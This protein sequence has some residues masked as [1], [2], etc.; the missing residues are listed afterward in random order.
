MS[1][2]DKR[3]Q[4]NRALMAASVFPDGLEPRDLNA[5]VWRFMPV[6]FFEDLIK[7]RQ[8]YFARMDRFDDRHEGL[9][10]EDYIHALRL[11]RFD[12]NDI[13]ARDHHIGDIACGRRN[14][15]ASCWY[16]FGEETATMWTQFAPDGG[17]AV[18]STYARLKSVI[19]S[20]PYRPHIGL[21]RYGGLHLTN[22]NVLRFISTKRQRYWRER[23]VRVML[24]IE[25]WEGEGGNCHIDEFNIPRPY[26]VYGTLNPCGLRPGID[27]HD[28]ISTVVVSPYAPPTRRK[29]VE[30]QLGEYGYSVEVIGSSLLTGGTIVLPTADDLKNFG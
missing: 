17:V 18:C 2:F 13:H 25:P 12:L 30:E 8:L 26:P 11:N 3:A 20:I 27:A 9:P 1:G 28:L 5:P 6:R 4:G 29:E 24:W 10:P 14:M 15:Y 19:G 16:L 23:E 7:N 21:V 22:W